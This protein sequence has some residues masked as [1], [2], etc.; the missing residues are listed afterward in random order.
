MKLPKNKDDKDDIERYLPPIP[1]AVYRALG[2]TRAIEFLC[3][4]GGTNVRIAAGER[5]KLIPF[6]SAD[7]FA[8]LRTSLEPHV[9]PYSRRLSLPKSDHLLKTM[10]NFDIAAQA[11]CQSL[12]EQARQYNL[13]TRWV[14][15]LRKKHA[16]DQFPQQPGLF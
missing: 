8:H 14:L 4:F 11:D 1:R 3:E 15:E 9:H 2:L 12:K 13:T 7:E 16:A 5:S 6:L 10:R